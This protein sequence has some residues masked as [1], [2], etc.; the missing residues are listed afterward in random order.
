[1]IKAPSTID[2]DKIPSPCFVL[3]EAHLRAN[4]E[5]IAEFAR[6]A[7]VKI[8]LALKGFAMFGAFDLVRKYLPGTTASSLNEALLGA[9]EFGGEVH[10][11]CPAYPEDE[12]EEICDICCHVTVNSLGQWERFRP[13]FEAR[14]D[15][16]SVGLRVNPEYSPVETDLYNPCVPG[17]RL[18][19]RAH[20]LSGGLPE[21]ITGLH[22]HN[23]CESDS[24]ALARTLEQIERLYGHILG[25]IRWL[26][27]GGGH[28][29]TGDK[30]DREHGAAVLRAFRERH[31][32]LQII[33]EPG[34]AIA[35]RTGVL[36]A[37]VLDVLKPDKRSIAMLD[38]S[39][40]AHMPDCL[41]MPYKPRIIGARD[42]DESGDSYAMGGLTC[43]AG[44]VI[45]DYAFDKPLQV[46][47]DVIFD[48]MMHYTMVKT[49]M[50][51]G[52]RHPSIGIWREDDS[53]ELLRE[54]GYEDYRN[55][56]G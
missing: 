4:L 23:L 1:M 19:A 51:N 45:G 22:V 10:A 3:E 37:R 41:E 13:L 53:F 30:Y 34:S 54:F 40:A 55:R 43:L 46:G 29:I 33:L 39:I 52:V 21:G 9:R 48:D 6:M 56:L 18:G 44:D 20:E 49:T 14:R 42:A 36:R 25:D 8:I 15:R 38:V 28:L 2:F 50:F 32:N 27:L 47:D 35:W 17:S 26:N 31:P 16:L 12:I 11:Y 7:D 24:H 5:W